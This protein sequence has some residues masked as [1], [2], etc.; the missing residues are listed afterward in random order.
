M[1]FRNLVVACLLACLTS[2][3]AGA[4]TRTLSRDAGFTVGVNV[5]MY[6]GVEADATVG[7]TYGQFYYNG[8][9]F[10]A[11][12]QYTPSV[13]EVDHDF[14]VPVAFAYR[15]G[16]RSRR[17]RLESGL[18]TYRTILVWMPRVGD[19]DETFI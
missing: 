19:D 5:P 6:K 3:V 12:F 4:Q 8:L 2:R 18:S 17:A 13:A 1:K 16:T 7:F 9:G 10:R 15:T 11:G 14:G